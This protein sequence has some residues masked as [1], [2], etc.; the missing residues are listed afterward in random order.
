MKTERSL[1][2]NEAP[3]GL[4]GRTLGHSYS[5]RIHSLLGNYEYRLFEKEPNELE[6]FLRDGNWKGLNVTIPYKKD[7]FRYCS[8]L[9]EAAEAIGSVNTLVRL[10]DGGI[11]GDNTDAFG[12]RCLLDRS[13][14]CV[15]GKKALILG[16]G[17]ACASVRYILE[18]QG[19]RTVVISRE[20]PD[21][22]G[23]LDR[24]KDAA[25]I[26]NTTPLG[27][28][29]E[30]GKQ[31][32]D[33]ALFPK[34]EA[35]LDLI[36]NPART[37][38]MLQAERMGIPTE[39][40]LYMLTAQAYASSLQFMEPLTAREADGES[41]GTIDSIY[42]QLSYEMQNIILIGMPGSGK[43]QIA[44]CLGELT[45]REVLDLDDVF[46]DTF[47]MTP[48]EC[49]LQNGEEA[50]R[51]MERE[52][53]TA[54]GKLSGKI[55]PTGGGCVTIPDNYPLLH[56]NGKIVWIRR[57]LDL[58]EQEGRPLSMEKGV[59]ALYQMRKPLY[60]AF[61]DIIVDNDGTIEDAAGKIFQA[62]TGT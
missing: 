31:A 7:A 12:F 19:A 10:P 11:Y 60:E 54:A 49:I 53:I 21:N 62:C 6:S 57:A 13:G 37:A 32:V 29:P 24:H 51:R 16:S 18:K 30:N 35:V 3:C 55:I 56:Q 39:S 28:Y 14:V 61:A 33:L 58:L 50:F 15:T 22:Y 45:D 26:V 23:N 42:H 5:P 40:G 44:R 38:L 20:G 43:T 46:A 59:E 2:L 47:S 48:G 52:V 1:S 25:L 9:S 36:Y 17:G 8:R 34:A 4:L 27:M 41:K